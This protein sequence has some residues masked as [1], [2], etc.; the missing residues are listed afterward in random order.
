MSWHD[1]HHPPPADISM[2]RRQ[3]FSRSATGI[4]ATALASLLR[5]SLFAADSTGGSLGTPHFAPKAKRVIYLFMHGGPSQLDLLD[6]K[7]GLRALHGQELPASV[8]GSQRLT[9]MTS[10]QKTL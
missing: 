6:Y 10:N 9:G 2:T 3:S 8:R 5:P 7:P 4:G 1:P